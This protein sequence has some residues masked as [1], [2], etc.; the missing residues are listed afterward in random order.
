M[1]GCLFQEYKDTSAIDGT[2]SIAIEQEAFNG[3]IGS[4][5]MEKEAKEPDDNFLIEYF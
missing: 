4:Q 3:K 5:G 2:R 1:P